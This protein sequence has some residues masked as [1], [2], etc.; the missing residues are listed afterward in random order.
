MHYKTQ[1]DH[2]CVLPMSQKFAW[3]QCLVWYT[4]LSTWGCH[5][6]DWRSVNLAS[7]RPEQVITNDRAFITSTNIQQQIWPYL[8][9]L[10]QRVFV[11][12][13][14]VKCPCNIFNVKCH[15]NLCFHN[16]NNN[17]YLHDIGKYTTPQHHMTTLCHRQT[18]ILTV[19]KA[20]ISHL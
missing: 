13:N 10:W 7:S 15:Y 2:W 17:N 4:D 12:I 1:T 3:R 5:G 6:F 8:I 14:C 16:N 18:L 19:S 20:K 9:P 11:V